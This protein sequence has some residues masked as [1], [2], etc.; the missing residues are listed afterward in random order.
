[1]DQIQGDDSNLLLG[2]NAWLSPNMLFVPSKMS[3]LLHNSF[4]FSSSKCTSLFQL[5]FVLLLAQTLSSPLLLDPESRRSVA[6]LCLRSAESVEG[7]KVGFLLKQAGEGCGVPTSTSSSQ[8]C[9]TYRPLPAPYAFDGLVDAW[10][11]PATCFGNLKWKGA[12]NLQETHFQHCPP[13]ALRGCF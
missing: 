8:A 7:L 3:L 4:F 10:H 12:F 13:L 5:I 2:S 1:M 11:F 6:S 9:S